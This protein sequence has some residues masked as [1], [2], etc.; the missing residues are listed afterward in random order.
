MLT[1]EGAEVIELDFE[2]DP[3]I[4]AMTDAISVE[5]AAMHSELFESIQEDDQVGKWAPTFREAQFCSAIDYV[6]AMRARVALIQKTEQVLR[7][8]DVYLGDGDLA[9]MNLTGHPSMVVSFGEDVTNKKPKTL[10]LTGR[11]FHE[12][13]LLML[14]EWIQR[15]LP[16]T[17]SQPELT[18]IL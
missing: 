4:Q 3:R 2:P 11:F 12:P 17:P 16:P 1:D 7:Q 13:Q 10:V 5:A 14:A 6:Q 9:R 15:K 18:R 8:V